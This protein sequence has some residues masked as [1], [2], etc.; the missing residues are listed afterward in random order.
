MQDIHVA[1]S[2]YDLGYI[3]DIEISGN[4]K[5]YLPNSDY[6]Q[7][8]RTIT[9]IRPELY[10]LLPIGRFSG[11]TYVFKPDFYVQSQ[12]AFFDKTVPQRPDGSYVRDPR[13]TTK[14]AS[15]EHYL[16]LDLDMN[17]WWG[18][19]T[20]AGFDEDWY[21]SSEA[22]GLEGGHSTR[23]VVGAGVEVRPMRGLKFLL[24]FE[25]KPLLATTRG[26]SVEMFR[27][28]DNGFVLMTNASLSNLF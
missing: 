8:Q 24:S 16:Q 23:A 11:L 22:E 10:F 14:R 6:S 12:T 15:L 19:Q 13:R 9:R 18:I 27:Q 17:R 26:D 2:H 4:L 7:E 1:Y 21:H 25:N 5:V 20:K 3:G 28:R